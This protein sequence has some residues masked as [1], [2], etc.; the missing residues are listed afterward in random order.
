MTSPD[1]S[2]TARRAGGKISVIAATSV[3]LLLGITCSLW[4]T[5][6]RMSIGRDS[7][8]FLHAGNE[9]LQGRHP[10][11]DFWDHKPPG[12]FLVNA[13]GL[14]AGAGR[15][16]VWGLETLLFLGS[17]IAMFAALRKHVAPIAAFLATAFVVLACRNTAF[18][19]SGNLTES[20]GVCLVMTLLATVLSWPRSPAAWFV[21]G[22]LA[23]MVFLLKPTCVATPLILGILCVMRV[24]HQRSKGVCLV[25]FAGGGLCIIFATLAWLAWSGVWGEFWKACYEYNRLYVEL[26]HHRIS[27]LHKWWRTLWAAE[28]LGIV[29]LSGFAV[30]AAVLHMLT[31]HARHKNS[32]LILAA[33]A[34]IL[35]VPLELWMAGLPGTVR[36]HYYMTVLPLLGLGLAL[37][38]DFAKQASAS[39]FP[40]SSVHKVFLNLLLICIP[41]TAMSGSLS[42]IESKNTLTGQSRVEFNRDDSEIVPL[43]NTAPRTTPLL[44]WGAETWLNFISQRPCPTRYTYMYPLTIPQFDQSRRT[45]EFLSAL[46]SHPDTWIIDTLGDSP[47]HLGPTKSILPSQGA[48]HEF[49]WR[50]IPPDVLAGLRSHIATNYYPA[51]QLA[52]GWILYLPQHPPTETTRGKASASPRG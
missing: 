44:V 23:G 21:A 48:S 39:L 2:I 16:G 17:S 34:V 35:G 8:V 9:I 49:G 7:G 38:V 12:I 32:S 36:G 45:A 1:S 14:A 19:V 25:G 10:Y 18:F 28:P 33:W 47:N 5:P 11:T 50:A 46:Q 29:G 24:M 13:A 26:Q 27:V 41:A 15:W 31:I 4:Y 6:N 3:L 37:W 42:L 30:L 52:N 51:R 43:V 40:H 20:Y 22:S